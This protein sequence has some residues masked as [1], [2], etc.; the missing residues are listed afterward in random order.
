MKE[1]TKALVMLQLDVQVTPEEQMML[2]NTLLDAFGEFIANRNVEVQRAGTETDCEYYA[3][4]GADEYVA[5]RYPQWTE[6]Q[7]RRKADQVRKRCR[8]AAI[9]KHAAFELTVSNISEV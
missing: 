2:R 4:H 6:I 7:Q 1:T 9:L 3:N 5:K 8:L